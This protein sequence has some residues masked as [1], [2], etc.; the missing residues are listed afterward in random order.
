M[1]TFHSPFQVMSN[2]ETLTSKSQE[3]ILNEGEGG[4]LEQPKSP[5][6]TRCTPDLV[7][8]LPLVDNT[9]DTSPVGSYKESHLSR[10]P[11]Q[12]L[13]TYTPAA[14][15]AAP[16]PSVSSTLS[17]AETFA[18]S[19]GTIVRIKSASTSSEPRSPTPTS[20]KFPIQA[21]FSKT[22]ELSSFK[23]SVSVSGTASPSEIDN[24]R[25]VEQP[26][27]GL[28]KP[29]RM[30]TVTGKAI[31]VRTPSIPT[32]LDLVGSKNKP[33][34]PFP[35]VVTAT[36]EDAS[37]SLPATP[38]TQPANPPAFPA[39]STPSVPL[40]KTSAAVATP[41]SE[42]SP[43]LTTGPPKFKKPPPPIKAKPKPPAPP[44][45]PKK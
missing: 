12:S 16:S 42:P 44:P 38:A 37:K 9:S 35:S 5:P 6:P 40:R 45:K 25:S 24:T 41:D 7:Q 18:N 27:V 36:N 2:L 8:D 34:F 4:G 14:V 15:P 11:P 32:H 28:S 43:A 26:S 3:N 17:A 31:Q 29:Q 30:P 22:R 39:V 19:D 10:S 21:S 13:P 20:V 1:H 33:A 23:R